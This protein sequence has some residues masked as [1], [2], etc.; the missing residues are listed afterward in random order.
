MNILGI[1]SRVRHLEYGEG[2]VINIKPA[3]YVITFMAVG[4]KQVKLDAE[5]DVIEEIQKES[6]SVSMLD[7][8]IT[9]ARLLQKWADMTEIVPIGDK[10]KGGKMIL[11]P[12][13]QGLSNKEIPIDA[14]FHKIV[15][16]RDRLRVMEQKVN[17]SK[18]TD[19]EKVDIQQY[20]TRI[21]G[22]MTT[23]NVL[24]KYKE[25]FFVGDKSE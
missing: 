22:S 2:V 23:F 10:W 17:A 11:Q 20:I 5:L 24:F 16:M 3:G 12:G 7:V 4:M 13:Q 19:Q 9:V 15:M 8:E 1:G 6:D 25:Q 21:Y 14:F 18:L